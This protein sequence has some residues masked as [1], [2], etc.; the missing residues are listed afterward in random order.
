MRHSLNCNGGQDKEL[1]KELI[2][3]SVG[4]PELP[5]GTSA[6]AARW[7]LR[8]IYDEQVQ[9]V[10]TGRRNGGTGYTIAPRMRM[11]DSIS[12]AAENTSSIQHA[13]ESTSWSHTT[14]SSAN[15]AL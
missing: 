3:R 8:C 4:W 5:C 7:L 13:F 1:D 12:D 11:H 15:T 10:Q 6:G 2:F 9:A 14:S